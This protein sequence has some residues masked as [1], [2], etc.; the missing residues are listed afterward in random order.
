MQTRLLPT[1]LAAA[2]MGW[3]VLA[4]PVRAESDPY[5]ICAAHVARAETN[6]GI[7]K[8]LLGAIA[9][10]ESGRWDKERRA[11]IAWPWTVTSGPNGQF[12]ASKAEAIAEVRRMKALGIRNIDVGCMQVNLHHHAEAFDSLDEAF[13]PA[14]NVA[15]AA[16]FLRSLYDAHQDWM[17]AA[18]HYHSATPELGA[19]YRSK[20]LAAWTG[21]G[22]ETAQEKVQTADWTLVRPVQPGQA[23]QKTVATNN[24][25]VMKLA[26]L[27]KPAKTQAAAVKPAPGP[28]QTEVSREEARAFANS[29]REAKLAE[30]RN[31]KAQQAR[32]GV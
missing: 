17:T 8:G 29:W 23:G 31:R 3:L 25:P 11:N 2:L 4:A 9:A 16:R 13:D 24:A 1:F 20:V 26:S 10:V 14:T 30:Y 32:S 7:P 5:A 15:Y 12:F 27:E 18:S 6:A 19:R 28:S 22:E 21:V